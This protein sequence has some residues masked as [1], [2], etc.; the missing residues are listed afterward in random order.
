MTSA[1]EL[2]TQPYRLIRSC[3]IRTTAAAAVQAV[4]RIVVAI[5]HRRE[6][7]HFAELDDRML[8]D[9]GLRRSDLDAARCGPLLQD[10]MHILDQCRIRRDPLR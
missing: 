2:V 7:A 4:Q 9:I 3:S 10:P 5:K 8:A 1:T 6:L